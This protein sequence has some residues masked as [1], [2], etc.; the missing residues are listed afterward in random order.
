VIH[1]RPHE[2][3]TSATASYESVY[4]EIVSSWKLQDGAMHIHAQIP[5]NTTATIRLPNA[6][7]QM[8]GTIAT[9][10]GSDVVVEVGSGSYDFEY[11][12]R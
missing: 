7:V 3:L 12:Y 1:P 11:P 4:G 6:D 5:T 10:D 2:N 9:Q 8:I